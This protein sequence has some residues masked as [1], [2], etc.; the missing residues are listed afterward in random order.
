VLSTLHTNT[1]A[2]AITRLEDMGIEPFLLSS[3]LVSVLSQRLVRTLCPE[4]KV[5]HQPSERECEILGLDADTSVEIFQPK[6]CVQCNYT[7]YRGRTGIHEQLIVDE[8]IREMMH[9]GRG[10][11]AIEKYIR[12]TTPSIRQDGCEKVLKGVTSLEEVLRVTR[13]E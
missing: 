2:G 1:A 3:S 7:G 12:Q 6:G 13:E 11:Q 8:T 5:A 4:C 10:E 9:E